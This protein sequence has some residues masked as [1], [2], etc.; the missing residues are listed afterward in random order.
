M[1]ISYLYLD[2]VTLEESPDGVRYK[3]IITDNGDRILELEAAVTPPL[4]SGPTEQE[5]IDALRRSD[6]LISSDLTTLIEML[7]D[8]GVL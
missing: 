2:P 1:E 5:Q 8:K 6:D 3:Q 7:A 4:P